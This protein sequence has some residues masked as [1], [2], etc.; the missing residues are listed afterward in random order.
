MYRYT[1][2]QGI[3]LVVVTFEGVFGD[4]DVI[5]YLTDMLA[6]TE[7]GAGWRTLIDMTRI[8]S[9]TMTTDG[10]RKMVAHPQAVADRLMGARAAILAQEGSTIYGISRMYEM[11]NDAAPYEIVVFSDRKEAVAWL[12]VAPDH[13]G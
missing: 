11:K 8:V 3:K 2:D 1:V 9:V 12:G 7:Y 6:N 10:V 5:E 13:T 4:T